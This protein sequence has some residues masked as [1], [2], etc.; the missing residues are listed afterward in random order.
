M[1]IVFHERNNTTTSFTNHLQFQIKVAITHILLFNSEWKVKIKKL[2]SE[3][4]TF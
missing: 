1:H 2:E 4:Y 3:H